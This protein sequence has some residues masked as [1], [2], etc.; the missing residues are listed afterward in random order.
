MGVDYS[1]TYGYGFALDENDD[2]P[3]VF[4][5]GDWTMDSWDIQKWLGANGYEGV[6]CESVG[7][8]MCGETFLFFYVPD[9]YFHEENHL[10]DGMHDLSDEPIEEAKEPLKRL[11]D[12][13]GYTGKIGWKVVGNVS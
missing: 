13:L 5:E 11:A 1:I 6:S 3:A 2:L 12:F 8:Y 9:T 10:F 4:K 7:N